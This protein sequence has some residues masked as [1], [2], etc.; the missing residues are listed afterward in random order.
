M[1]FGRPATAT[2]L[3]SVAD[4]STHDARYQLTRNL[5]NSEE[6][7]GNVV[8]NIYQA[9]L[10]RPAESDGRIYW[11]ELLWTGGKTRDIAVS[12]YGS[13]EAFK[14]AGGT[15]EGYI[16]GLYNRILERD[17]DAA[18]LEFWVNRLDAGDIQ[19]TDVVGAFWESIEFRRQR[20]TTVYQDVL[21]RNADPSGHAYWAAQL[22]TTDDVQLAALLA[23]S[24]EFYDNAQP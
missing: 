7:A 4:M 5:A 2:E 20:V 15:N 13:A 12:I 9:A 14:S 16:I 21:G 17:P 11:A 24:D 10:D 3:I 22:L 18:G 8:D 6:W 1:F 19:P 23:A